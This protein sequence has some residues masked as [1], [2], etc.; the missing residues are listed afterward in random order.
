MPYTLSLVT[1]DFPH[2]DEWSEID[3]PDILF[4]I[5]P[6]PSRY[7]GVKVED[8]IEDG[9]PVASDAPDGHNIRQFEILPRNISLDVP[10]WLVEAWRRL[11]TRIGYQDILDRQYADLSLGLKKHT[12]N[13]LQN[14]C[15]REC[16]K[17]LNTWVEYGRRD[18]PHRTEVEAIEGMS[19]ENIQL[20]TTLKRSG[21]FN[22]RLVRVRL[23]RRVED[24]LYYAIPHE[25]TVEN[26]K[27]TTL[28]IDH[29]LRD[30]QPMEMTQSMR[31]AWEMYLILMERATVHGYCHWSKLERSC[32][33]VTWYDRTATKSIPNDTYD[34]GCATCTWNMDREIP[35]TPEIKPE[36]C[37]VLSTA[38]SKK[39]RRSKG[40]AEL[41]D[42]GD[43]PKAPKRRQTTRLS[44][45]RNSEPEDSSSSAVED[46]TFVETYRRDPKDYEYYSVSPAGKVR[47]YD[48]AEFYEDSEGD[49]LS[50]EDAIDNSSTYEG[51]E[52]E[53]MEETQSDPDSCLKVTCLVFYIYTQLTYLPVGPFFVRR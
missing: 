52:D 50:N 13:A 47:E 14:H 20:N 26:W 43:T 18:E 44:M 34:G 39:R 41:W 17:V 11:D 40:R 31:A 23:E 8:L 46:V 2:K 36:P 32:L 6:P 22:N 51:N 49:H 35:G 27:E 37:E 21:L 25:V 19:Y 30:S 53:E 3:L 15:R 1:S 28:P 42:L 10:G 24:G 5:Q 45:R 9:A 29:F 33:P 48:S 7:D 12:K 16:R 38:K 4:Y